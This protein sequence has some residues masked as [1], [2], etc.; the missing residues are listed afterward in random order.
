MTRRKK[1][2]KAYHEC[3]VRL[4]KEATP[5]ADF[6][7]LVEEAP[8]NNLGQKVI[9]FDSYE[10]DSKTFD[11]IVEETIEKYKLTSKFDLSSFRFTVYLGA[12]PR[13]KKD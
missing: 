1:L 6:D 5:S 13:T 10:L 11:K 2:E 4:Y 3:M 12:S 8:L 7:K 9:D